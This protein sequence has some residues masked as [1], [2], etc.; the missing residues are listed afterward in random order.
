MSEPTVIRID[1]RLFHGMVAINWTRYFHIKH[2]YII[3]DE[4]AES[5]VMQQIFT[6]AKPEDV[7]ME[8]YS[9]DD[10]AAKWQAGYFEESGDHKMVLIKNIAALKR[11]VDEG[12]K[13]EKVI[14]GNTERG[15]GKKAIKREFFL[16]END[17]RMLN[18]I[19]QSGVD[20]EFQQLP[21]DKPT[22]WKSIRDKYFKKTL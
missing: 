19:E 7:T 14:V 12:A 11:M 15:A 21:A 10:A 1:F 20:L 16:D 13:I 6:M 9:V 22:P 8:F 2:I 4:A 17:A 5:D 3:D 18:D